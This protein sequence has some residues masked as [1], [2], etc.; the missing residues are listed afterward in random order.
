MPADTDEPNPLDEIQAVLDSYCNIPNLNLENDRRLERHNPPTNFEQLDLSL[1]SPQHK[2]ASPKCAVRPT[3]KSK[4][5]VIQPNLPRL[6]AS[7]RLRKRRRPPHA[8][9]ALASFS[10]RKLLKKPAKI[11]AKTR[12][13]RRE[14]NK[15]GSSD[16]PASPLTRS[17]RLNIENVD[18]DAATKGKAITTPAS[19]DDEESNEFIEQ[20]RQLT[21]KKLEVRKC[22]LLTQQARIHF[23]YLLRLTLS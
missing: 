5:S 7:P 14:N 11:I 1:F 10:P 21:V 3:D 18:G 20:M 9:N 4:R 12:I 15:S 23:S 16:L 8:S 6:A 17:P 19:N 2:P 22:L 13:F